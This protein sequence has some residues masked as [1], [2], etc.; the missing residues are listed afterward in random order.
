MKSLAIS[1]AK[2]PDPVR[3]MY[4]N[5]VL[6]PFVAHMFCALCPL[7]LVFQQTKPSDDV[8]P[9]FNLKY[10]CLPTYLS[11]F[12]L[13]QFNLMFACLLYRLWDA[14]DCAASFMEATK[15]GQTGMIS[16]VSCPV[17]SAPRYIQ[18]LAT[19][20]FIDLWLVMT[21]A[22]MWTVSGVLANCMPF[23]LLYQITKLLRDVMWN[24]AIQQ[25]AS[26]EYWHPN[27]SNTF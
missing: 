2:P 16:I 14:L 18:D 9:R 8:G 24:T 22:R 26:S 27:R 20:G 4:C 23:F 6:F 5:T 19:I 17:V 11:S 3:T 21:K 13:W 12:M 10:I 7:G 15:I 25:R 1:T